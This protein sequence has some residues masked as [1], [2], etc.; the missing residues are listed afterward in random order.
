MTL[1]PKALEV[2]AIA[3]HAAVRKRLNVQWI[4]WTLS[5]DTPHPED[6]RNIARFIAAETIRAYLQA[7]GDGWKRVPVTQTSAMH[8]AARDAWFA[9]KARANGGSVQ[10][11]GR[12]M[13]EAN[14]AATP[15]K[16]E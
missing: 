15:D 11:L 1:N 10:D 4:D 9:W 12:L 16:G 5:N 14:L 13:W 3:A 6:E 7:D 2:A 8:N